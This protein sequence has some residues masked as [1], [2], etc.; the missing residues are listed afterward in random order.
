MRKM[1]L[2]PV[3]LDECRDQS[4]FC[5][6]S[7]LKELPPH[8][9]DLAPKY[10]SDIPEGMFVLRDPNERKQLMREHVAKIKTPRVASYC[11]ECDKGLLLGGADP[12]S[13]INL[14][15]DDMGFAAQDYE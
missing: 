12:A 8:S 11:F 13:I 1:N 15:F 3:E 4:C 2:V 10:F 7:T 6:T 14:L 9:L 5:G